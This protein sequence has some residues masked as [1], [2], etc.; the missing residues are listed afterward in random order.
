[1][2]ARRG[3][4][5]GPARDELAAQIREVRQRARGRGLTDRAAQ[6]S[7]IAPSEKVPRG[8]G[9]VPHRNDPDAV[10]RRGF[11]CA[12][13]GKDDLGKSR[14]AGGQ[15]EA[16]S[17]PDGT[18]LAAEPELPDDHASGRPGGRR[19]AERGETEGDRQIE[20]RARFPEVGRGQVDRDGAG[21]KRETRVLQGRADAL[22]GFPDGGVRQ[23]DDREAGEPA[24]CVD[25][26]VEHARLEAEGR[27][28]VD[29]G[30]HEN[31]LGA[32]EA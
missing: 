30:E 24:G 8:V 18:N 32:E 14:V 17:S 9:E 19:S 10:D 7:E 25:L 23:A 2:A 4:L 12:R 6:G 31:L 26:D 28:R 11:P 27:G 20:G 22:A 13:G 16:E 1:M 3:D 29:T 21:R 5:G 15:G